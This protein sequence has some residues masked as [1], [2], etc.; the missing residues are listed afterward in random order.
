MQPE[1]GML[2]TPTIRLEHLL[3]QGGMGSVWVATHLKF[4]IKVVVKFM[5]EDFAEN[6]EALGRFE[7]EAALAAQAKSPHVVHIYDHGVSDIGLPY[8]AME[9]LEGEDLASRMEREGPISPAV[10]AGWLWQACSGLSKAHAKGIVHRDVKPENIFLCSDDEETLVKVLDFG[11]AK[12]HTQTGG[13]S[14]TRTGVMM[15]TA[16]YMS[17]EQTMGS[18]EIDQRTDIWALGATTYHALT[19]KRPFDADS[20]GAL[21]YAITVGPIAPPSFH[22]PAL[23]SEVDAWME[24]ALARKPAERFASTKE[25]AEAFL[26]AV[27]GSEETTGKAA[28][29]GGIHAVRAR[30][31]TAPGF[32]SARPQTS[33]RT[34]T[35]ASGSTMPGWGQTAAPPLRKR[36]WPLIGAAGALAAA[37]LATGALV[38]SGNHEEPPELLVSEFVLAAE[39]DKTQ[40]SAPASKEEEPARAEP[41]PKPAVAQPAAPEPAAP[42]PA[43]PEPAAPEP[44]VAQPAAPPITPLPQPAPR[45]VVRPQ[46]ALK[47]KPKPRPK[48]T[49]ASAF[50]GRL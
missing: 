30:A 15:G 35:A 4:Y 48:P 6:T 28:V 19:G 40:L 25:M 3:G 8:I 38:F 22:N 37:A 21:V 44:A 31:G 46:A 5:A 36:N 10:Y 24:K 34:P 39:P 32:E 2:I 29:L 33:T 27:A 42:E 49:P 43:A 45:P 41:E 1:P 7:R 13:F 23:S 12:S 9:L 47:A 11:I 50:G 17:P 16:Y 26:A 14:A 20:L 18:K